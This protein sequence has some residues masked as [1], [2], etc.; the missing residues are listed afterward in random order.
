[1]SP[2]FDT[3][4]VTRWPP[5]PDTRHASHS[6]VTTAMPA[7][8]PIPLRPEVLHQ[9]THPTPFLVCDLETVR[10]R[11]AH[12]I[13]ALPGVRCFYAIKCN[14]STEL[15]SA[16]AGLGASF[17]VASW[18]E[19]QTLQAL[20]V[21]PAEVLYSN[22]VKP[23]SH[24]AE[25]FAAG[26]WRF[27]FDSEGELYKLAQHAPGSA[28]FVRLRV[29]DSTSLFPLSRKFG[30]EAQ[31]ARALLLLARNLGLRPYGVTFHVGSQC[32]SASAWRQAIAAVG[33]LLDRL[34]G[35]GITLEMVNL[36][37]GFPARYCEPVPRSTRSPT[38]SSRPCTSCSP[39][40]PSCW[41]WSPG[42]TWSPRA[43]CWS[44]ACSA[45]RSAPA[46]TGRTWTSAPT[47]A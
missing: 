21:D 30:A 27:A 7:H 45:A 40:R 35:D 32:T 19:L 41:R 13:A 44:A 33:R 4:W 2:K 25:S 18:S 36:G 12:L 22:T 37:G 3:P 34:S 11:Y 26:L 16:F 39:T 23:A 10:E 5:S 38:P 14:A 43:R 29:D 15:L 31:E 17:E 20:G 6:R 8:W 28:V 24:V 46:R 1:M 42:A 9:M 47:T